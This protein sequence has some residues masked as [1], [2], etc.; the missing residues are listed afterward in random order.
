MHVFSSTTTRR[1]TQKTYSSRVTDAI[2]RILCSPTVGFEFVAQ[3]RAKFWLLVFP[4]T[5]QR[6]T[7]YKHLFAPIFTV[8]VIDNLNVDA[9]LLIVVQFVQLLDLFVFVAS[10]SAGAAARSESSDVS[11]KLQCSTLHPIRARAITLLSSRAF[12]L[13]SDCVLTS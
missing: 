6:A 5:S 9:C 4:L 7:D 10:A 1:W 12:P 3:S 8:D 2:Y 13:G 11:P